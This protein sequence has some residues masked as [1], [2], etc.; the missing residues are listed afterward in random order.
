MHT[1]VTIMI[2]V[3]A[4]S[5]RFPRQCK[6]MIMFHLHAYSV[7]LYLKYIEVGGRWHEN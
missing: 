1:I 7:L 6:N 3:V 4:L 2:E 5:L